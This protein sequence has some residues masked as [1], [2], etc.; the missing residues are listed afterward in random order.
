MA[1]LEREDK[2]AQ[3]I[4]LVRVVLTN[5]KL[6][7]PFFVLNPMIIGGGRKDLRDVKDVP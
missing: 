7:D 4:G 2:V 3:F 5:G 1:R 6:V